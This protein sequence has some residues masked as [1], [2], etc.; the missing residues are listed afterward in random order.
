M[1]RGGGGRRVLFKNGRI[2]ENNEETYMD[3]VLWG[4]FVFTIQNAPSLKELKNSIE[5]W[6]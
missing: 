6:V 1:G 5:R 3:R 2:S 4:L